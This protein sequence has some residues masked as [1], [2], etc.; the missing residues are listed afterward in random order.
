MSLSRQSAHCPACGKENSGVG[1]SSN[2]L[3]T[4]VRTKKKKFRKRDLFIEVGLNFVFSALIIFFFAPLIL[5]NARI[6][7][8]SSMHDYRP[9]TWDVFRS[10]ISRKLGI[11]L[12]NADSF[13]ESEDCLPSGNSPISA[14]RARQI[15]RSLVNSGFDARKVFRWLPPWGLLS[16][17]CLQGKRSDL[18]FFKDIPT[19][20][21]VY[22]LWKS[23]LEIHL[24]VA[25][26]SFSQSEFLEAKPDDLIT[27]KTWNYLV[28]AV[29]STM[30]NGTVVDNSLES[31][32]VGFLSRQ[33]L[34]SFCRRQGLKA[35][36]SSSAFP[37]RFE[38]ITLLARF[39]S[40]NQEN[41]EL[42]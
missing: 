3:S 27:R 28:G 13:A 30:P 2:H 29:N 4:A 9:V 1:K 38:A 8:L 42:Q 37:T 15:C 18:F 17:N 21:P 5:F 25:E 10:Q 6:S 35:S 39:Y 40:N 41:Y 36:T 34:S 26:N 11:T 23:L 12:K 24:P 16:E 14:R 20:H 7:A 19:D 33:E 22:H 32:A 31:D